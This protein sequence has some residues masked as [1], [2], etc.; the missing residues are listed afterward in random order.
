MTQH[1]VV[2]FITNGDGVVDCIEAKAEAGAD[3]VVPLVS[4]DAV[5]ASSR[6]G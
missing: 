2:V 4:K 6:T 1:D 5:N 3:A